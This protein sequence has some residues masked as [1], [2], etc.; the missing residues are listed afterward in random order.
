MPS[1][2]DIFNSTIQVGFDIATSFTI[3]GS[4]AYFVI[5][6]RKR[7]KDERV[8]RFDKQVRSV[9]AEQLRVSTERLSKLF[10]E[11]VIGNSESLKRDLG[12]SKD[13]NFNREIRYL[14][15]DGQLEKVMNGLEKANN[16]VGLFFEELHREKYNIIPV[17]DS[18]EDDSALVEQFN[19]QI[20][21][22]SAAYN[23]HFTSIK[24]LLHEL[25]SLADRIKRFQEEHN[26]QDFESLHT[27]GEKSGEWNEFTNLAASIFYDEAYLNWTKTFVDDEDMIALEQGVKNTSS[28]SEMDE[29]CKH[30]FLNGCY[31]LISKIFENPESMYAQV[32][33]NATKQQSKSNTACK[34][35]LINLSAILKYL[36]KSDSDD[37]SLSTIVESY[38]SSKYFDLDNAIR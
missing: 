29:K 21:N 15:K 24:P 26:I 31:T 34:E 20:S 18:I 1:V 14:K 28:L 2:V 27:E 36:L 22:I 30:L 23:E 38:K 3:I 25:I 33:F 17:I 35:V 5:S 10:I 11:D 32:C 8:Q 13:N 19:K 37:A 9:A 4:L 7:S 16:A 12:V 6:M